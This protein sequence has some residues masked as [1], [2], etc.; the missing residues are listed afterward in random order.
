MLLAAL[1]LLLWFAACTWRQAIQSASD[2]TRPPSP[3][4]TCP[5]FVMC[6][7]RDGIAARFTGDKKVVEGRTWGK[8]SHSVEHTFWS[9]CK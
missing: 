7:Y 1:G 5:S 3:K 4:G 2:P 6:V 8:Y 9:E